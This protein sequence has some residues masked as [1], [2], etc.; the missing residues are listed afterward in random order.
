[1]MLFKL[2]S[3]MAV[4]GGFAVAPAGEILAAPV[5]SNTV[6][7]KHAEPAATMAVRCGEYMGDCGPYSGYSW[8][9]PP[10]SYSDYP[11]YSYRGYAYWG[12]PYYGY[13]H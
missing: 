6:A 2:A 9:Y 10:S 12:Y 11:A 3:A 7:I 5:S 1:M 8:R 4:V 13:S